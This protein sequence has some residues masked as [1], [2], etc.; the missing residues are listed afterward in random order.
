MAQYDMLWTVQ[1]VAGVDRW[2]RTWSCEALAGA[3]CEHSW[4]LLAAAYLFCNRGDADS[5]LGNPQH[6][7]R[8]SVM[9]NARTN[10]ADALRPTRAG[11]SPR[12]TPVVRLGVTE[13]E[14][15]LLL[16]P[17]PASYSPR[18]EL[19][20]DLRASAAFSMTDRRPP[21]RFGQGD[22][23]PGPAYPAKSSIGPAVVSSQSSS[24]RYRFGTEARLPQKGAA[25]RLVAQ[26]L[27][28]P[29]PGA[30]SPRGTYHGAELMRSGCSS[31]Q[32][33]ASSGRSPRTRDRSL[34][35]NTC[36]PGPAAYSPRGNTLS[37]PKYTMSMKHDTEK[38][39]SVGPGPA[40][41]IPA[42]DRFGTATI[43]DAF[44]SSRGAVARKTASRRG[45]GAAPRS[46]PPVM[47]AAP[48]GAGFFGGP[49]NESAHGVAPPARPRRRSMRSETASTW[50]A[51][52][53]SATH[54][55]S[56]GIGEMTAEGGVDDAAAPRLGGGTGGC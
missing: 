10:Y 14:Q 2:D 7:Q 19:R 21:P 47:S 32:P 15:R 26:T 11:K 1:D 3:S 37:G 49:R 22:A 25:S 34:A 43:G 30:Y 36:G 18:H 8:K 51:L 13:A 56:V 42:A 28:S 9:G 24:P 48:R 52:M 55:R 33:H 23:G 53:P 44:Q 54:R 6:G 12:R 5:M 41:Y 38:D 50:H 17:G 46:T 39:M 40:N 20:S 45:G 31:M 35:V 4:L 27:A 16:A 29:G